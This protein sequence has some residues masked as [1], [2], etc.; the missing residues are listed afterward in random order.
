MCLYKYILPIC[1]LSFRPFDIVF[2]RAEVFNLNERQLFNNLFRRPCLC[3]YIYKV[4]IILKVMQ[5][6]PLLS[7]RAFIGLH[8]TFRSENYFG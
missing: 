6:S 3:C 8:F 5:F 4:I 1:G 7:S 2:R